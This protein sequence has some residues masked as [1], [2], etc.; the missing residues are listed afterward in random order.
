[1]DLRVRH[2]RCLLGRFL[3]RFL[4]CVHQ[5]HR[6]LGPHC[7]SRIYGSRESAFAQREHLNVYAAHITVKDVK[8]CDEKSKIMMDEYASHVR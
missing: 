8:D 2:L 5:S 7:G 3:L 1:M 6:F 4:G